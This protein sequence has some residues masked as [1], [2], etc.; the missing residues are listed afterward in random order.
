MWLFRKFVVIDVSSKKL[1]K[2]GLTNSVGFVVQKMLQWY[3][4]KNSWNLDSLLKYRQYG[5]EI[6]ESS[7]LYNKANLKFRAVRWIEMGF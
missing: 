2:I 6:L 3:F 5:N 1:W 4:V 7:M